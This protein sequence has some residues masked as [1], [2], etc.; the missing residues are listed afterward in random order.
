M[1]EA[2][3]MIPERKPLWISSDYTEI[4]VR[5]A[6]LQEQDQALCKWLMNENKRSGTELVA[7]YIFSCSMSAFRYYDIHIFKIT[8]AHG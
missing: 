5:L 1:K 6:V 7:V 3:R 8:K 2:E 4:S